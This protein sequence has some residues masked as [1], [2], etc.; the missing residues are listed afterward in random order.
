MKRDKRITAQQFDDNAIQLP[1]RMKAENINMARRVLVDGLTIQEA[2][3]EKGVTY[4]N[5]Q[6]VVSRVRAFMVRSLPTGQMQDEVWERVAFFASPVLAK[7]IRAAAKAHS[8]PVQKLGR[9]STANV[10]QSRRPER[11]ER[12]TVAEF[13]VVKK[14]LPRRLQPSTIDVAYRVFVK[15]ESVAETAK[16]CELTS[17]RVSAI[18]DRVLA[19]AEG[20]PS[21]WRRVD[22]L[23][24]SRIAE[25]FKK[26]VE[27]EKRAIKTSEIKGIYHDAE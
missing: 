16:A 4:Q 13:E 18:V 15:G 25:R 7:E 22:V 21:T 17:P 3:K 12:M 23:L 24:P 5:G 9:D 19:A 1:R 26:R 6:A 11:R 20:V 10:E 27:T 14:K 2:A 8:L